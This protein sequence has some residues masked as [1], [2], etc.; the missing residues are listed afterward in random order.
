MTSP[1]LNDIFVSATRDSLKRQEPD[2]SL[3]PA[4]WS[5]MGIHCWALSYATEFDHSPYYQDSD[6]LAAILRLG[7]YNQVGFD[8]Q[9]GFGNNAK[10][11][12]E[13]RL[14]AWLEAAYLIDNALD[15]GR[16][17][18][19]RETFLSFGDHFKSTCIDM[20][21]FD[22]IIPNHGIWGHTTFYRIG[23]LCGRQDFCDIASAAFERILA[24]QTAD[25]CFREGDTVSGIPGTAV[26][27]YNLVSLMAI[28]MYYGYTGDPAAAEALEKGWHWWYD[29]LFPDFSM[30]PA[31]DCRQ[32]YAHGSGPRPGGRPKLLHLPAHFYNKPEIRAY[33][34]AGWQEF[35]DNEQYRNQ[36]LGFF[37]LQ[38]DKI[39]AD[40][41]PT[42][43]ERPEY[44]RMREEEACIR[45][46]H[47]WHAV[48][49]GM[50][51][52][53]CSSVTLPLWRLERQSLVNLYHEDLGLIIGSAHSM[54]Q[55]QISTFT[56][57]ENGAAWYLHNHAY[58]KSTPPLDSLLLRYG[59][60]A[61]VVSV[62]TNDPE[63]C[64]IIFSIEGENGKRPDRGIGHPMTAMAARGRLPLRLAEGDTIVVD[65]ETRLLTEAGFCQRVEA[66]TVVEFPGWSITCEE[67]WWNLH[68][69]VHTSD[70]YKV[71]DPV[72]A[73][74]VAEVPLW[75]RVT[76]GEPRPTATFTVT[77]NSP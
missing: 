44:L 33:C 69:P 66:G 40:V 34:E 62:D 27:G 76:D 25:G 64:R 46:R 7:D 60:N 68:W 72:G 11:W 51:N 1:L 8:P 20:E 52:D 24:S 5:P 48:L 18:A 53:Y 56:F 70:P 71:L 22:G 13:W 31:L 23:Q 49:C 58:L 9:M 14:I 26:T 15:D 4:S 77:V 19:W 41:T 2:G 74:A 28:N 55:E 47:K 37:S 38:C 73:L 16:R 54:M 10:G 3:G 57:Y 75:H 12:D 21:V 50:T 39:K 45:R 29:F 30:P 59:N 43:V 42:A 32:V 17:Q 65:G 67:A 6:L 36:S 61:A 63:R 35:A